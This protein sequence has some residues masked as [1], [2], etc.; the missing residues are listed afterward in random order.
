MDERLRTLDKKAAKHGIICFVDALDQIY[1]GQR[2]PYLDLPALCPNLIWVFSALPEFPFQSAAADY[3][4]EMIRVD[5]LHPEQKESL[6]HATAG[7]RGKKLDNTLVQEITGRAGAGNP[8]FL[9]LVLQRFFMMNQGEFEAAE[10]LAPGMEGLHRYMC[11][12]MAQMPDL[13]EDMAVYILGA[14]A[15]MFD[16]EQFQEVLMLI[17][18]S[19]N[20]LTEKELEEL[21]ALEDLRFSQVKFQQIVSYLYDAFSQR[22][23][24]KWTFSHRLFGEAVRQTMTAADRVRMQTLLVR[25]SLENEDFLQREG[26]R[27]LLEQRHMGFS[28]ALEACAHWDNTA[29]IE[30]LVG[31]TAKEQADCRVFLEKM[32]QQQMFNNQQ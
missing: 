30:D 26:F 6:I 7:K 25:Y 24:G 28:K 1:Q 12:L 8:L 9:S 23:N 14:T 16:Q 18:T 19:Q 31:N 22:S 4:W 29:E 11:D 32:V 13:P 20:G 2:D 17:A 10:A 27:Y 3:A 5:E 15:K 21:L